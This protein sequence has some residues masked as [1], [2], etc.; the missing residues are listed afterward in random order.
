MPGK[1]R[2]QEIRLCE[3]QL[4]QTNG[5]TKANDLFRT[6]SFFHTPPRIYGRRILEKQANFK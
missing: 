3:Q 5:I 6:F 2:L 1:G 4:F